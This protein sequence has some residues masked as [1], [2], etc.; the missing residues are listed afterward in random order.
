VLFVP[1]YIIRVLVVAT[2]MA[3]SIYSFPLSLLLSTT[4][5]SSSVAHPFKNYAPHKGNHNNTNTTQFPPPNS[6]ASSIEFGPCPAQ[7]EVPETLQCATFSVPINWDD[8]YG[9]HFDL[10]LVKLPA[11]ANST[12]KIGSAF[13]NPGGPGGSAVALVATLAAG[14]VFEAGAELFNSFDIIGLD[15]RGVGTSGQVECDM[16]IFAERATLFPDTQEEYDALV[17]KN[18]RLGKSCR[19]K[20]GPLFDYLDTI[21]AA[22]V[23]F[24]PL[25]RSHLVADLNFRITKPFA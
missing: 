9:E 10:G 22:K 17:D 4:L 21:S 2:A 6:T 19:E 23:G 20:T 3:R 18:E 12:T 16:E 25:H 5:I 24:I 1:L 13:M 8:P 7:L 11:P 14:G 15:P